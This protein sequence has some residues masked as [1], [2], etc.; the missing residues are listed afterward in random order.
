MEPDMTF[1]PPRQYDPNNVCFWEPTSKELKTQKGMGAYL[2]KAKAFLSNGC[3]KQ[4]AP[5]EWK[6]EA[7][8]GYNK[9]ALIIRMTTDGWDCTCQGF[10]VKKNKFLNG[11]SDEKPF[12][13]HLLA[14]KQFC[15]IEEHNK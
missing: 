15:F 12:C 10:N 8:K 1:E 2:S 9:Q 11:E 3:I 14:V 5:A 13:S 6:C 7:L 4:I